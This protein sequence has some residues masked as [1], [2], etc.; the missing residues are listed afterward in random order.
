MKNTKKKQSILKESLEKQKQ[1]KINQKLR[2]LK[3]VYQIF[4]SQI[5]FLP[6]LM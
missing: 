6:F 2:E 4:A 5:P 1:K 3:R